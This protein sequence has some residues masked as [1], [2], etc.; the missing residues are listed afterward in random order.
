[1]AAGCCALY[2]VPYKAWCVCDLMAA[3]YLVGGREGRGRGDMHIAACMHTLRA[4][5]VAIVI[6]V[7]VRLVTT[8]TLNV[9]SCLYVQCRL[10]GEGVQTRSD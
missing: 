1:M 8:C 10:Q 5:S 3:K 7:V 9:T 6:V 2:I 4:T